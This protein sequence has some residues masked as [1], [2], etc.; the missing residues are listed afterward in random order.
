MIRRPLIDN[1][2]KPVIVFIPNAEKA[3]KT[4]NAKMVKVNQYCRILGLKD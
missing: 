4:E 2:L 1:I 3:K